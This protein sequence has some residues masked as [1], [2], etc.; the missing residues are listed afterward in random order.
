[1]WTEQFEPDLTCCGENVLPRNLLLG[2]LPEDELDRL[3]PFLER[4]PLVPRRVLQHAGLPIEH[5]IFIEDGLVSVLAK[6]DDRN[7]AEA[8]LIGHDGVVGATVLLGGQVSTLSHF[9]Q[10]GGSALRIS[11][12]DLDRLLPELPCF[13]EALKGYLHVSLIQSSQSAACSLRHALLPRLARWLLM[14]HDRSDR[15]QLPITQ[16][17]LARSLGV[18]RPTVSCAFKELESQGAFVKDRGVILITDRP[19]L[20]RIA[21]RCYRLMCLPREQWKRSKLKQRVLLGFSAFFA[22]LE[23]ELLAV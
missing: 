14:A 18:R 2:S 16:D 7:A 10:I 11:V 15:D 21:C 1:M 17:L 12:A 6:V 13:A 22:T 4:V 5:L 20:E 9:V 19:I 3:L 8:W 23:V